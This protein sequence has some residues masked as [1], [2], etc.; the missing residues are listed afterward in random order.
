VTATTDTDYYQADEDWWRAY[1]A[2]GGAIHI[3]QP[4][5]DESSNTYA[6][7]MALPLYHDGE[8]A[9]ILRSTLNVTHLTDLLGDARVAKVGHADLRMGPD[10]LIG[11]GDLTPD[12][13]ARLTGVSAPF[14]EI[15][16]GQTPVW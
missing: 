14:V 3:S 4:E 9:G 1:N 7:L 2:G 12:D 6:V 10:Q 13:L 15:D 16:L 5:F 8:I 11:S